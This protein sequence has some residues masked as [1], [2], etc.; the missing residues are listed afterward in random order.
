MKKYKINIKQGFTIIE[1]VL[2]LAIAGLIFLM[3][4][5][6]LPNMQRSQRDTQRRN[7]YAALSANITTYVTN[8]NGN[9]PGT[10]T[11]GQDACKKLATLLNSKG[12]DPE[13]VDYLIT[14]K[15]APAT[16]YS[17]EALTVHNVQIVRNATC[18]GA[19]PKYKSGVRNYAIYG[20]IEAAPNTYCQAS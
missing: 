14:V 19:K 12:T 20:Y 3:V 7:D 1:V 18:D 11:S 15:D 5:I 4:F 2:V 8:N 6:A 17:P 13:G 16:G 10:C 9:M